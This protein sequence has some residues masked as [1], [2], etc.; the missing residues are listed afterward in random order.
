MKEALKEAWIPVLTIILTILLVNIFCGCSNN[1]VDNSEE[2]ETLKLKIRI[3]DR[4]IKEYEEFRQL[5]KDIYINQ[6]DSTGDGFD[7]TDKGVDFWRTYEK[8]DT[9]NRLIDQ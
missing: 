8:I 6:V 4:V 3:R 2:I 1:Q 5:S 7:E 9:L